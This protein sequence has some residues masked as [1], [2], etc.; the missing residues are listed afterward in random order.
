VTAALVPAYLY[1]FRGHVPYPDAVALQLDLAAA[2]S[3]GAIPDTVVLLEHEPVVTLGPRTDA[4]AEVPDRELLEARGIAVVETDRGGRATYHG[5]G[6][7]VAYP[8]VD[9]TRLGRDL[10]AYVAILQDAVVATLAD[11]GVEGAP[12]EGK[13]FVGVWV[14]ERKIASIG[15]HVA[16]WVTTHGVALNVT[17]EAAEPFGLFT[18]CGLDA[19]DVTSIERETG[20][21]ASVA[22]VGDRLVAHL[23]ER[24]GLVLDALPVESPA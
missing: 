11:V 13:E 1:R 23:A 3:Q 14:G 12:R 9:L 5:P 8:I 19:L 20:E 16:G 6:Q 7:V 18:A 22:D 21:Q 15:V 10:R 4:D 2:R 17:Q 24:L